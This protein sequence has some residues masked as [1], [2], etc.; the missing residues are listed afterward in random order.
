MYF[1]MGFE[2][3]LSHYLFARPSFF[4]GLSR[5]LDVGGNFDSYNESRI[6]EEADLRATVNDWKM[7]GQDLSSAIKTYGEEIQKQ[8][9]TK[10]GE[11]G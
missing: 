11:C 6:P 4:E 7:V 5:T 10:D 2:R 3:S 8:V 9:D 1:D